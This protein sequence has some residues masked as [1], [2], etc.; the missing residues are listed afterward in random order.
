MVFQKLL[1]KCTNTRAKTAIPKGIETRR[2]IQPGRE[3]DGTPTRTRTVDILIK[4]EALYQ[5][6]Y[7]RIPVDGLRVPER[8]GI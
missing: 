5:L 7:G 1:R 3:R 4:S 2:D 8:V 6:S